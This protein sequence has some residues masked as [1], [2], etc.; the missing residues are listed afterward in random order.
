MD[1][2]KSA[3]EQTDAYM[4][5]T[6]VAWEWGVP[7]RTLASELEQA[8]YRRHGVPTLKALD[9]GLGNRRCGSGGYH[10][11]RERVGRFVEQRIGGN[12]PITP[13]RCVVVPIVIE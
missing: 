7:L 10:W 6:H 12:K 11:S 4:S 8:G 1:E 5:L 2:L 9:E 3:T 13:R